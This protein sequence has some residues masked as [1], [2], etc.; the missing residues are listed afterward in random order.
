[1]YADGVDGCGGGGSCEM[2]CGVQAMY[3]TPTPSDVG[4]G[5]LASH[6]A[7]FALK[8]TTSGGGGGGGGDCTMFGLDTT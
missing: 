6:Q 2:A 5:S 7:W 4:F 1:M 8:K 3:T